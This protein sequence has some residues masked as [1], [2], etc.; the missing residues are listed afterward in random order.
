MELFQQS[1][2][3]V[4]Q[5]DVIIALVAGGAFGLFLGAMPGLTATMALALLVPVTFFL[6][7]VPALSLMLSAGSMAIF[8]GDLP[9]ALLRIPGTPASAAYCED[10]FRL[11]QG[12]CAELGLGLGLFAS[13]IG[14]L[15]GSLI[16]TFAAPMLA[17]VALNFSSYEYFWLACLGLTCAALVSQST[18][19]KGVISLLLGLLVATVGLDST[20]GYPRFTFGSVE[21]MGGISFIPA[22][23]GM[24]AVA[25]LV[26]SIARTPPVQGK[27][28]QRIGSFSSNIS[29]RVWKYR[30]HATR[31]S[32]L[33][34]LVGA[35]P[36]AGA[37]IAAWV[38]YAI[39]KRLS[40][41]P[42]QFGN[43][44]EEGI[45]AASSAN[46]SSIAGGW[47]P[48]LVFG[49][50]G[51]SGA[52]III[53]VLYLK[54]LAPGPTLFLYKPEVL[55]AVFIA[56]FL[57]NIL[58][59]FMGAVMIRLSTNILRVPF[60]VL[61]PLIM[62]FCVVGAFAMNNSYFG[63]GI[64]MAAGVVAFALKANDIPVAPAIL[65]MVLGGLLEKTFLTSMVKANGDPLMFFSR[66]IAASL[67]IITLALWGLQ[68]WSS[69]KKRQR[70]TQTG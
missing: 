7:P 54:D 11:T 34:T 2:A 65:G 22:M 9:G 23:I 8:A 60:S 63:V 38:S 61:A 15:V 68:L 21:M 55:Y 57:A 17:R 30:G 3:L 64:M 37:D 16:L 13:V 36:G 18:P 46:N 12:G 27:P 14:G 42:E 29:K 50:P 25:E 66:P 5:L 59:L 41:T 51:D 58:L 24:F 4:L 35:L 1:F 70:L 43:G 39:S 31:G 48:T 32:I 47:I 10:T 44:S 49:I 45:V 19:L 52:A 33:G 28:T 62:I 69:W 67:G 53:G 6:P 40:K 26:N 20:T 56:F